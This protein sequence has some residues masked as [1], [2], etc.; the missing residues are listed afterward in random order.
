MKTA[1]QKLTQ[2]YAIMNFLKNLSPEMKLGAG[3]EIMNPFSD[4]LARQL[5]ETFYNKFYNDQH[6]R[7]YIFGINPG[8]FGAGVTGVPLPILSG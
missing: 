6:L 1:A 3:I 4:A 2:S 8:R 7:T 5:A